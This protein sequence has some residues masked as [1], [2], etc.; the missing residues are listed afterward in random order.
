LDKH[1]HIVCFDVPYPPDYGG[2][3]DVFCRIKTLHEMGMKIHLHCFEY[4]RGEQLELNKYCAEVIYYKRYRGW[5]GFSFRLPYIVNSRANKNLLQNLVK[6]DHPVFLEGIHCTYFLFTNQLKN[7]KILVRLHNVE[8]EY[9]RQLAKNE[10]SFFKRLYFRNES[11]LLKNYEK[12]IAAKALFLSVTKKDLDTYK[13]LFRAADIKYLPVFLPCTSVDGKEGKGN[14]SLYQG[15]LSVAENEKA[16]IWLCKKIFAQLNIPFIIAGK[17]PS[18]KLAYV[19]KQNKNISLINN[20]SGEKIN[21]LIY[22]A[23][24]N[25]LPSFNSTGIKVKLLNAL[26]TGRHCIVNKATVDRTGLEHLCH[27]AETQEEFKAAIKQLFKEDFTVK[28]LEK[29]DQLLKKEYDNKAN[30]ALLMQWIQ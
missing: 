8:F 15:N 18:E 19:V 10:T 23:Q 7:K 21:E 25:T 1:L 22:N 5:N 3:I 9:Y 17:N 24:I 27:I 28:E 2:V 13:I 6:D 20:P 26:F 14:Y 12:K 30:A 16:A 4:G 11:R 29:R